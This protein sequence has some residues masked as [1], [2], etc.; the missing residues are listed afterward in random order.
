M[1]KLSEYLEKQKIDPR[2]ILIASRQIERFT[3][4]D[5]AVRRARQVVKKGKPT[6]AQKSLAEKRARSG[7]PVTRPSLDKALR[8][9]RISSTTRSR[10]VRALNRILS[11]KKK[12]EVSAS[13]VF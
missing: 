1:S 13:D 8:G 2:R 5:Y 12:S 3:R 11:Q 10:I 6:D 4:E 9:E 7:R